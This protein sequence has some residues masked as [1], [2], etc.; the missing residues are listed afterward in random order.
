MKTKKIIEVLK[1]MKDYC[2]KNR[3]CWD[4]YF[5]NQDCECCILNNDMPFPALWD[6]ENIE[7]NLKDIERI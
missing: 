3:T 1:F 7:E 4:C 2:A 6:I 5:Y